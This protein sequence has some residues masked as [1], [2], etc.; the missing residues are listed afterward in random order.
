[1]SE[2]QHIKDHHREARI[3]L[4]RMMFAAVLL[5]VLLGLLVTRLYTLQ[6][7]DHN[8]YVT[9]SDRNRVQVQPL[10][11][12]RGLIFDRSGELLADNRPSFTLSLVK[13]RVK[14]LDETLALLGS[15]ISISD[16]QIE[17]F[18]KRLKQRRRPYEATPLRYRLNEDEIAKVAVNE[19]RLPG[20]DV[21]AQLV[22]YYPYGNLL[23]HSV[24]YVGRINDRELSGFDEDQYQRYSGTHTLGKIGLER[25]YEE[26]L[27]GQVGY[28]NV[29][30][31]ARGR[32]L[33]VLERGDPVPGKNLHLYLDIKL[34]QAA[35]D[36]LGQ[37]RGAVVAIDVKTGGVLAMV[38]T[39]SYD[40]NLFV[41]GISYKDYAKLNKS[42]DLPLYNRT[43]Q[44]Q[45]PPGSTLKPMLGL[46]GLHTGTVDDNYSVLDP[47]YYQLA[48]EERFYRDWK[49]TGHGHR[50]KLNQAIMESCDVYFY[51]LAFRMGIDRMSP[52]GDQFGLGVRTGVD[53]PSERKGLW[54][55]RQ[56]KREQRGSSWYPGDSLNMGI[57][58]G[59]VLTTPLQLASLMATM[60][61]QGQRIQPLLA[62]NLSGEPIVAQTFQLEPMAQKHWDSVVRAMT[63][64]VHHPQGTAQSIRR[65][66]T[67][68]IAGKTGTAQVVGIAQGAEYDSET[69]KERQR[70]HALFVAYAPVS[71]PQIAIAVIVENGEKS[72][73]AA[74]VAKNVI[75]TYMSQP[76]TPT[77][78]SGAEHE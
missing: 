71:D 15:L 58:Q 16:E 11:P 22:R 73:K 60:G 41:T 57:G 74:S 63:N 40:P 78:E 47:G 4:H 14:N 35:H 30:T 18:H 25:Y 65:G 26:H 56:W 33:R 55:S 17:D 64:V 48:G 39:P 49:K 23:A 69:L 67:Y 66:L 42:L 50:V 68:K 76:K 75:E 59:Y 53:I 44:G 2:K 6:V 20:I 36:S 46:G 7:T 54:P 10:P 21:E 77:T 72:S 13:E 34:Q 5:F 27:L 43:I 38:S 19:F 28:Q 45:Y 1:M 29:E 37:R 9:Q 70:D 62:K 3:Y 52:F 61:S 32:V 31:N 8:D 51:D 24:G 12:T